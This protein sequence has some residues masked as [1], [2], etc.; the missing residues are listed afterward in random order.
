[1]AGVGS[2]RWEIRCGSAGT[3][4]SRPPCTT[5]CGSRLRATSIVNWFAA[6]FRELGYEAVHR[7]RAGAPSS[8]PQRATSTAAAAAS[9][10][11]NCSPGTGRSRPLS[12]TSTATPGGRDGL[13]ACCERRQTLASASR[14]PPAHRNGEDA[15]VHPYEQWTVRRHLVNALRSSRFARPLRADSG[16]I[17]WI[18]GHLRLLGLP[19]LASRRSSSRRQRPRAASIMVPLV[20]GLSSG[21]GA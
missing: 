5:A 10:T 20:G 17:A 3:S 2:P 21:P 18:D 14:P 15:T 7:T 6:L 19:E 13:S 4:I 1:L 12:A 16:L 11:Y 8:P 9:A